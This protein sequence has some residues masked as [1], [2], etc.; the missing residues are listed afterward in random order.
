MHKNKVYTLQ[1]RFF[2]DKQL[3]TNKIRGFPLVS[4]TDVSIES[5]PSIQGEVKKKTHKQKHQQ[6]QFR[7]YM[8]IV[9]QYASEQE[10]GSR[11]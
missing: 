3:A 4:Q 9:P 8:Y 6:Q 1:F 10:E 11:R 5:A 7:N 2:T